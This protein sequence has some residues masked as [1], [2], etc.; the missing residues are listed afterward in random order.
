MLICKLSQFDLNGERKKKKKRLCILK[1]YMRKSHFYK[2]FRCPT[3]CALFTVLCKISFTNWCI[4][5]DTAWAIWKG[6]REIQFLSEWTFW[7]AIFSFYFNNSCASNCSIG[8]FL[9]LD[10][11]LIACYVEMYAE[12]LRKKS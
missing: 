2:I 5:L 10:R 1:D 4:F 8:F 3:D 9:V 11:C 6:M 12:L 7:W